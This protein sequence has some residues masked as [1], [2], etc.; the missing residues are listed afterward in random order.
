MCNHYRKD[1]DWRVENED[2]SETRIPPRWS[3]IGPPPNV[4]LK[5][6]VG[7][8]ALGEFLAPDGDGL[9]AMAGHWLWVHPDY[10]GTFKAYRNA[11]DSKGRNNCRSEYADTTPTWR[12]VAK[13]GRCLIPLHA[14]YEWDKGQTGKKVEHEF[15]WPDGRLMFAAGLWG[16][17][18]RVE[19]G[20]MIGF[21][22]LTKAPGGDT[23][24]IGH[25]RQAVILHDEELEAYLDP[26]VPISEFSQRHDP[27]Y[28]F[29]IRAVERKPK[30]D[31]LA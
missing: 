25:H 21:S 14:F 31:L 19:E 26:D 20:P 13:T 12:D 28:T 10:C 15:T 3:W 18:E 5:A 30:A 22:M 11:K 6:H 4:E 1:P 7:P 16:R 2:W 17:A 23:A 8:G 24:S 27:L 9:V 29:T